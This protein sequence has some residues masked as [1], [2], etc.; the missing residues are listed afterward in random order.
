MNSC[1]VYE[2]NDMRKITGDTLR[3]GGFFLTDKAIKYCSF[4]KNHKLLDIGCGMGETVM[5]LKNLFSLDSYGIDPSSKLLGLGKLKY[6]DIN[7]TLG[8]GENICFQD[9]FFNGVLAE[10]TFS[11]M[12]SWKK[13]L[14]EGKRVLKTGGYFIISDVYGRN[15]E[16]IKELNACNVNSCMRG[17]LN[18]QELRGF[19]LENNFEV[20]F[21]ED[22]SDLLKSLMGKII[23]QYG[24]MSLFW[25]KAACI[26]CDDF[27]KK[28]TMCKPG[29]FLMI[30]KKL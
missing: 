9:E 27:E 14:I 8:R 18:V 17:L 10:C 21:M 5:R 2:S 15:V 13:T 29:Y 25:K 28:L 3:P 7:I 4:N 6:K 12:S 16:H 26:S 19:A 22:Y 1:N 24:S 30:L 20:L 11:L 23:F